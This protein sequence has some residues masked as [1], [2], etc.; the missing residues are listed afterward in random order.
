[1]LAIQTAVCIDDIIDD[2]KDLNSCLDFKCKGILVGTG[3]QTLSTAL[4]SNCHK[5]LAVT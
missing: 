3:T 5:E 2:M 1:M 4:L